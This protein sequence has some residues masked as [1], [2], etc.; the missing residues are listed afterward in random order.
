MLLEK[1]SD[2]DRLHIRQAKI[3][4]QVIGDFARRNS[5]DHRSDATQESVRVSVEFRRHSMLA[6]ILP[7]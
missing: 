3:T 5:V 6:S 1:P 4:F 2:P 7:R